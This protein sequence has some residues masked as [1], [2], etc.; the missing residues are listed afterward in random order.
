[1]VFESVQLWRLSVNLPMKL[2]PVLSHPHCKKKCFF[3][4]KWNHPYFT[5]CLLPLA[6]SLNK[7][8]K[9]LTVFSF[10]PPFRYLYTLMKYPLQSTLICRAS[11]TN[12]SA[13]PHKE[14][15]PFISLSCH[16]AHTSSFFY[17]R[18]LW[19]TVSKALLKSR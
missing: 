8:E 3:M 11:L 13:F 15:C 17:T 14:R 9:S 10:H 16:P 6:L 19:A 1:M 5:L 18:M 12:L 2:V 7:T 4:F